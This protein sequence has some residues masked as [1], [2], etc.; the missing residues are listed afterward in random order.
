MKKISKICLAISM[1]LLEA[2]WTLVKSR[3]N[4]VG[5]ECI[6]FSNESNEGFLVTKGIDRLDA[7][8]YVSLKSLSQ[9]MGRHN[10]LA[11]ML[12]K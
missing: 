1:G 11:R 9:M 2:K 12:M 4:D 3:L 5:V 7:E 10:R 8:T 6:V